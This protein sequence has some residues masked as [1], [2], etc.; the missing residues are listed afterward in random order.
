MT[1]VEKFVWQAENDLRNTRSLTSATCLLWDKL[2]QEER[3][4]FAPAMEFLGYAPQAERA[5]QRIAVARLLLLKLGLDGADPRWSSS[6]LG[7]LTEVVLSAPGASVGDLFNALFEIFR[8]YPA[9]LS[10]ELANFVKDLVI[11][12][13]TS[14]RASYDSVDWLAFAQ[15]ISETATQP[16]LY[17]VLHAVPPNLIS[18]KLAALA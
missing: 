17:L 3:A 6:V 4:A 10:N 14:H 7:R 2:P 1:D 11:Q 9:E 16:Q 13:H 18:P 12:C 8:D 5:E 15:T